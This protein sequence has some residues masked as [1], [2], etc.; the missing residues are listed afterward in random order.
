MDC[1]L[2][3][4]VAQLSVEV[5]SDGGD[6]FALTFLRTEPRSRLSVYVCVCVC[7]ATAMLIGRRVSR[8]VAL[9]E[10]AVMCVSRT[11][12]NLWCRVL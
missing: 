2:S 3:W 5:V 6:R 9:Q 1:L 12:S 11:P 7:V 8:G 10:N 4:H